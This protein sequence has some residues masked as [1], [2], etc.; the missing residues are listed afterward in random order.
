MNNAQMTVEQI[1]DEIRNGASALSVLVDLGL[2]NLG[3]DKEDWEDA[4]KAVTRLKALANHLD[5]RDKEI[6]RR[7]GRTLGK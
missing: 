2:N 3:V 7:F 1:A 5:G 6:I 4:E